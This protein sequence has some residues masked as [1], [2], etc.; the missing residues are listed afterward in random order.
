MWKKKFF[1]SVKKKKK[2]AFFSFFWLYVNKKA[3]S[4]APTLE[5]GK[6]MMEAF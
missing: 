5:S 3:T 1:F 4:I 6:H 2:N